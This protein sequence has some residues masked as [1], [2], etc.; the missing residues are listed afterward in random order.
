L[1]Q[2]AQEASRMDI[3]I[4]AVASIGLTGLLMNTG[5]ARVSRYLL[6]WRSVR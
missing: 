1:M 6:R 3:V 4:I 2:A 5:F